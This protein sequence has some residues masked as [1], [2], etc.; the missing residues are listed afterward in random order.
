MLGM[1][2]KGNFKPRFS[3]QANSKASIG[4]NML[5]QRSRSYSGPVGFVR[6]SRGGQPSESIAS[7]ATKLLCPTCKKYHWGQ[8]MSV[9][10]VCYDCGQT[11]HFKHECP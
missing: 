3:G 9:T 11:E 6:G 8:C 7:S 2:S 5:R 10:N 1:S 4:G